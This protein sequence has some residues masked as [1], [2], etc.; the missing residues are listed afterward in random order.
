MTWAYFSWEAFATLA[1]GLAAVVAA[2]LIGRRQSAILVRQT[3]LQAQIAREAQAIERLKIKTDLF[4]HR[5]TVYE[6][7][8]VWLAGLVMSGNQVD[9]DAQRAMLAAID[10]SQF[11][12]HR[13][14]TERLRNLYNDAF[15]HGAMK[16]IR[17][18]ETATPNDLKR[19]DDAWA[20][21]VASSDRL[22][23]L[24]GDELRL[25]AE[26]PVIVEAVATASGSSKVD[27]RSAEA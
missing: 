7:V 22:F 25:G 17:K 1:T 20:R 18:Y 27:A 4:T 11:L 19:A 26:G 23:E 12:F 8:R 16:E 5:M 21:L 24:F 15:V 2:Y 3:D 6:D 13:V 14:V 10:R 9:N